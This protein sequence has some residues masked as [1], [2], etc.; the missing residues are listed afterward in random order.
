MIQLYS[1]FELLFGLSQIIFP[2][3][4]KKKKKWKKNTI[5]NG[6]H[7]LSPWLHI[8]Y[9]S[10]SKPPQNY[11]LLYLKGK[12]S[13]EINHYNIV[14]LPKQIQPHNSVPQNE[15]L[16]AKV[17]NGDNKNQI[18][19]FKKF[20]SRNNFSAI[21]TITLFLLSTY[22]RSISIFWDIFFL[23]DSWPYR[24]CLL[25]LALG[26]FVRERERDVRLFF[27]FYFYLKK[28]IILRFC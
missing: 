22:S 28:Y 4:D 8:W 5:E 24:F 14:F 23:D 3:I 19:Q 27:I 13:Q 6:S 1:R 2:P 17:C 26:S 10:L 15:N 7:L 21:N 16:I 25:F 12:N 9:I 11:I 18:W 20:Q